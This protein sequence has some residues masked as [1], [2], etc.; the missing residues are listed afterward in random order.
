MMT[1]SSPSAPSNLLDCQSDINPEA[2]WLIN[3]DKEHRNPSNWSS[4]VSQYVYRIHRII[5][6]W[7]F[8]NQGQGGF[9]TGNKAGSTCVRN[10]RL[11]GINQ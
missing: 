7:T 8:I 3:F 11:A 5:D 6:N 4:N 2:I 1:F 10:N 9:I